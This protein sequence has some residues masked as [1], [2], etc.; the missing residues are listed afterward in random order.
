MATVTQELIKNQI[1]TYM[2][3]P[4]GKNRSKRIDTEYDPYHRDSDIY[5]PS[6]SKYILTL[7]KTQQQG[8]RCRHD[9]ELP[10]PEVNF[11]RAFT[12]MEVFNNLNRVT[13]CRK[14]TAVYKGKMTA[15]V[16]TG[17]RR[18]NAKLGSN[19]LKLSTGNANC[20]AA[21]NPINIPTSSPEYKGRLSE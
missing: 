2:W 10:A 6:N 1:A 19:S 5:R 21:I 12:H 14:N 13:Y 20:R 16:C 15:L 17:L 7:C 9:D 3:R 11:P 4:S 18:P 8:Y